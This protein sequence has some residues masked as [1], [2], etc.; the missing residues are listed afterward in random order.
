M[1]VIIAIMV[2]PTT[3][4]DQLHVLLNPSTGL[5]QKVPPVANAHLNVNYCFFPYYKIMMQVD[6]I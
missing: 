4:M 2:M 3:L 1:C 5:G 6:I